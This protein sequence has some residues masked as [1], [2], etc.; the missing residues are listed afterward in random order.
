MKQFNYKQ[1]DSETIDEY[2][3]IMGW[4]NDNEKIFN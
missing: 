4:D 1:L 2:F 3:A